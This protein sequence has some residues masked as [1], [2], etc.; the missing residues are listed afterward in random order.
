[1]FYN[2]IKRY[3]CCGRFL[4]ISLLNFRKLKEENLQPTSR[5]F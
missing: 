5:Q 4:P 2:K 1:M 3:Y